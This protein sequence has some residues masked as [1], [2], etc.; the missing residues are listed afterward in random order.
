MAKKKHKK[1]TLT[2]KQKRLVKAI[3]DPDVDTIAEAA[4]IAGYADRSSG[5]RSLHKSTVQGALQSFINL[6]EEH[7]A[8][9]HVLARRLAEGL[10]TKKFSQLGIELGLDRK[11]IGDYLDKILKVKQYVTG[12]SK[13]PTEDNRKQLVIVIGD[14]NGK[15]AKNILED[16]I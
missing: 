4:R 12:G 8:T 14:G 6:L 7:G 3:L 1:R 16:M 13:E 9:D 2:K 10:H 5:R 15:A 11:I